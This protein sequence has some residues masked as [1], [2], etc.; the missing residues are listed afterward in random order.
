M[1]EPP[2]ISVWLRRSAG[3]PGRTVLHEACRAGKSLECALLLFLLCGFLA[4]RALTHR[5]VVVDIPRLGF[6]GTVIFFISS[7][8]L[9]MIVAYQ[10]FGTP[11]TGFPVGNDLTDNKSLAIVLYWVAASFL[12]RAKDGR[13]CYQ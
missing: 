4:F 12:Y 13:H 9:G 11:W 8:P 3:F 7:F 1:F 6:L 2:G 5:R 10:T